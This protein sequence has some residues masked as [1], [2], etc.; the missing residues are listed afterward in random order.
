MKSTVA[1]IATI[2]VVI[3]F[4]YGVTVE[5]EVPRPMHGQTATETGESPDDK[6]VFIIR[7]V[8]RR[9][10]RWVFLL[11]LVLIPLALIAE[12]VGFVI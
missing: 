8:V 4:E 9:I 2:V 3:I 10:I 12:A 6:R 5:V 1:A 7:R 11:V